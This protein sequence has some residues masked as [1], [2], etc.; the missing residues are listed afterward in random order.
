MTS[1]PV[2]VLSIVI[3]LALVV[4]MALKPASSAKLTAYMMTIAIFGGS[5]LYGRGYSV[6]Y[7]D[8]ALALV[9]TPF[10]VIGM[11]LG[12]NDFSAISQYTFVSEGI[13]RFSFWLL[14]LMAFYSM[15]SA[16]MIAVGSEWLRRLRLFLITSGNLTIIYGINENSI[17]VGRECLE[18]GDSSVVYITQNDS[19]ARIQEIINMGLAVLSGSVTKGFS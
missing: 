14:H 7:H 11:F 17:K 10:S 19:E 6:T 12:K 18:N 3:F 16:A 9:R 4:N 2:I 8:M 1:I 5:I 15:T 13:G